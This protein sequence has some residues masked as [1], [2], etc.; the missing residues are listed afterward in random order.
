M[1]RL[2]IDLDG[3]VA[4]FDQAYA[5]LIM[6]ETGHFIDIENPEWPEE[7]YWDRALL[8]K[9]YDKKEAKRLENLIWDRDI[10]VTPFWGGL[11]EY[12]GTFEAM[13]RLRL[14]IFAGVDAYFITSRPGHLAKFYTEM[15]LG[16]HG[17]RN[18]TVLIA[19]D[20]GPVIAGLELDAFVDDKPENILDAVKARPKIRA[21]LIDRPYNR[22]SE[23]LKDWDHYTRIPN[24]G[25]MLDIELKD[26]EEAKAA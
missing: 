20:K 8:N 3:V 15:W 12:P 17:M 4:R 9:H 26:I 18:P 14:S 19:H 13:D 7:W 25:A 6:R 24:L 23:V 5:R 22:D 21:Y 2:G 11:G 16:L 10:K 1:K